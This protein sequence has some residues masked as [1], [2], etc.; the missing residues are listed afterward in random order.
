MAIALNFDLI[1]NLVEAGGKTSAGQTVDP[2]V[3][4]SLRAAGVALVTTY[5]EQLSLLGIAQHPKPLFGA[6]GGMWIGYSLTERGH[7]LAK[8]E[9]DLKRAVAPLTGGPRTEVSEA[10]AALL[11]ECRQ[12]KINEIYR[13]DF[14]KTL[15][16][17]RICFDED[18]FIAAIALCGKILEVCLKESLLR[19]GHQFDL[20]LGVG[21][22]IKLIREHVPNEY[23]DPTLMNVANIINTSRITAVH[24]KE[25][26]PIPSRDQAIMV[27]FATRDVVRR[28]LTRDWR[29]A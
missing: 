28:N 27:I 9:S 2:S 15:E 3:H 16:E 12:A 11:D 14:L 24:A 7:S 20:N 29:S 26:I 6:D 19:H 23:F 4:P 10:V 17:I 8:S 13:E 5:I 21:P 1:R 25:R 18:C 22:L